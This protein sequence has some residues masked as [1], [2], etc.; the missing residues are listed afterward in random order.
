MTSSTPTKPFQDQNNQGGQSGGEQPS[1]DRLA[2]DS[3]QNQGEGNV[4]AA[5]D[6]NRQTTDFARSGQVDEA[7]HRARDALDG[8][9]GVELEEAEEIG[10]SHAREEDPQVKR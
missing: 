2:G 4:T 1:H 6:Y 7:A 5:R 3:E 9:E 8:P 10:K